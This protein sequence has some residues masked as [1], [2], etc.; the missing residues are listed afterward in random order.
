MIP[1]SKDFP[2]ME[3]EILD[4]PYDGGPFGAKGGG[5]K[6]YL[7]AALPLLPQQSARPWMRKLMKSPVL[8]ETLMELKDERKI[9]LSFD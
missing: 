1:T 3:C 9:I 7:T 8:P 4:N 2:S 6:W 5:G